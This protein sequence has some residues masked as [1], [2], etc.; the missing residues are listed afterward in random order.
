MFR[1]APNFRELGGIPVAGGGR[2]ARGR[3]YR[4]GA[5]TRLDADEWRRVDA[6]N[7]GLFCE[8]RS[9]T[10]RAKHPVPWPAREPATLHLAL[11]PDT[12]ASG[13][14][15]FR[16]LVA[17]PTGQAARRMLL[18]NYGRMAAA[19]APQLSELVDRL[20]A[21]RGQAALVACAVGQD[22]TGVVCALLLTGLGASADDVMA[23]YLRSDAVFDAAGVRRA[24]IS[25]AEL[26]SGAAP[27]TDAVLDALRPNADYLRAA[28]AEIE[29]D[30]G[31][32]MRYLQTAGGLGE[33]RLAAFREQFIEI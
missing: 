16:E 10:E 18:T 6:L 31:G 11:L 4:S 19:L 17:D 15:V 20:L 12:R 23:D 22:R 28:F 33:A 21:L 25:G 24:L 32:V 9:S 13:I 2:V 1:N 3:L 30:Y 7:I 5:L 8:L 26:D 29:R 27:P 14:E